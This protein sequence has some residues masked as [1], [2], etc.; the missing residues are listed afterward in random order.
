MPPRLY[1]PL[2][3]SRAGMSPGMTLSLPAA[4]VRHAQVLRLQPGSPVILFDGSGGQWQA[5][6]LAM[7]RNAVEVTLSHH[8]ALEREL[9][10][11]VTLAVCMPAND[12]MDDLVEKA[13]ELGVAQIVPLMSQRSVLR[14]QGDRGQRKQ[15]HWQSVAV[16]ACEQSGRN[17]VPPVRAV[18]SLAAFLAEDHDT[19]GA[20]RLQLSLAPG[21]TPLVS[22][23]GASLMQSQPRA[24]IMIL[25]GPEGGLDEAEQAAALQRGWEPVSL[26]P[27]TLRADTAPLAALSALAVL[28]GDPSR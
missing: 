4:A 16:A 11:A 20:R 9:P 22:A 14:L 15:A 19:P 28:C 10:L 2:D 7:T 24:P 5:R 21:A 26:G 8:E 25:S 23:V 1:L 27:R 13:C 3:P 6:V 17:R 12:R 18:S